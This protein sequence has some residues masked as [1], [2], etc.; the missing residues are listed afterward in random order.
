MASITKAQIQRL[1]A[2]GAG[3]GIVERGNKNDDFHNLVYQKTG[4]ES[5]SELSSAEFE[6]M[7][8]ELIGMMR[9]HNPEPA[10]ARTGANGP[11][12]A[13]GPTTGRGAS[14]GDDVPGM[15]N[16]S[17]QAKAWALIYDLIELD[18]KDKSRAGTRM[19]GAIKT[20]L[21]VDTGFQ[22]PFAWI[23]FADGGKLIEQ[24]KRYVASEK[25]KA[26]K[27]AAV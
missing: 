12:R 25:R 16:K 17:Q 13:S 5:V 3:I 7:M 1:Y 20:I 19:K 9:G 21:G 4:K 15:M 6:L 11:M 2:L 26:G 14:S 18:D 24:L 10:K 8:A 23:S 27:K 22:S